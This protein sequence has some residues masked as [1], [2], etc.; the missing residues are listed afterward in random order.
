MEK[1]FRLPNIVRPFIFHK[2]SSLTKISKFQRKFHFSSFVGISSL[3][4]IESANNY[5]HAYVKYV[6]QEGKLE[7]IISVKKLL[8]TIDREKYWLVEVE[9]NENPPVCKLIEKKFAYEKRKKQIQNTPIV[10][11]ELQMTW[12][13][14]D[15]DL[16]H[17]ISRAKSWLIKGYQVEIVISNR[18]VQKKKRILDRTI[19]DKI[20]NELKDYSKE[21]HEPKWTGG[22]VILKMT[23]KGVDIEKIE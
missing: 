11:K 9:S 3:R 21:I 4:K 23:G 10:I 20:L 17:K 5:D 1:W 18:G 16:M 8:T 13:V 6:N 14:E 19:M 22:A 2:I 15:H 7:G 12:K